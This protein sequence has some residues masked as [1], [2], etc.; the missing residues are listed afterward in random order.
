MPK[1]VLS[2]DPPPT[3]FS[4]KSSG[5]SALSSLI[6][7]DYDPPIPL[8]W[9]LPA[10]AIPFCIGGPPMMDFFRGRGFRFPRIA[11]LSVLGSAGYVGLSALA[12]VTKDLPEA[13][14]EELLAQKNKEAEA[15]S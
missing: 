5:F 12:T 3:A 9:A 2:D 13:R 11:A 6:P 14:E 7:E 8:S 4:D 10:V 1:L 15:K